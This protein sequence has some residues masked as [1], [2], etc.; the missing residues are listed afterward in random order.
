LN[1]ERFE[2]IV[3]HLEERGE[4]IDLATVKMMKE[5]RGR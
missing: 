4:E 1:E 2:M 3:K 5:Q